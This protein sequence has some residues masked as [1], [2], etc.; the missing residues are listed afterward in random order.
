MI[1]R[2]VRIPVPNFQYALS[3]CRTHERKQR[4]DFRAELVHKVKKREDCAFFQR[5]ELK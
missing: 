5:K 2:A 3:M 1:G 4:R